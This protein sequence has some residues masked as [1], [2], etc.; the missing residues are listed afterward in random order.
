MIREHEA[1]YYAH[2]DGEKRRLSEENSMVFD[3]SIAIAMI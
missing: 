3:E 1:A 2:F